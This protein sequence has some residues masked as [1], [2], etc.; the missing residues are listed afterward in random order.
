MNIFSLR[1]FNLLK[2]RSAKLRARM[3]AQAKAKKELELDWGGVDRTAYTMIKP[4][5]TEKISDMLTRVHMGSHHLDQA[6][7]WHK[8]GKARWLHNSNEQEYRPKQVRIDRQLEYIYDELGLSKDLE[9]TVLG[10]A[11]NQAM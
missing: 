11:S 3:E 5:N 6:K 7:A 4:V 8:K 10:G 9:Q 2:Q 1:F